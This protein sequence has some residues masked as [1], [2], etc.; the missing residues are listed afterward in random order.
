LKLNRNKVE[1][2][3]NE[4]CEGNYNRFARELDLDTSHIYRYLKTGIGGGRK[5]IGAVL[6]F[7]K[8]KGLNYEDFIE[9]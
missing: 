9:L 5:L 2:L 7:T 8:S 6:E 4:Y 3:L 1:K